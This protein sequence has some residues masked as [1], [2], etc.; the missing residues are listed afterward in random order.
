MLTKA[1]GLLPV[2]FLIV[3]HLQPFEKK[4]GKTG[5]KYKEGGEAEKRSAFK[6]KLPLSSVGVCE[7]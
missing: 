7:S 2:F 6:I 1:G 4:T 5:E 3:T